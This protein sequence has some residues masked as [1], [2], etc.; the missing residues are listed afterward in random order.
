LNLRLFVRHKYILFQIE[1]ATFIIALNVAFRYYKV[2]HFGH[3]LLPIHHSFF[4]F[5]DLNSYFYLHKKV[6]L[7]QALT[8]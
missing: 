1:L 4:I 3:L 5:C 7:F 2:A 6:N 8:G